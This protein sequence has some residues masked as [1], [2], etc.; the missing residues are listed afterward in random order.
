MSA[1][2]KK[3]SL[4]KKTEQAPAEQVSTPVVAEQTPAPVTEQTTTTATRKATIRPN[5]DTL[6]NVIGLMI[7]RFSLDEAEVRKALKGHVPRRCEYNG[8]SKAGRGDIKRAQNSYSYY[9]KSIQDQLK[10]EFKQFAERNK[11]MSRRWKAMSEAERAPF[12]AQAAADK[13]RYQ[14]EVAAMT[15]AATAP[16]PVETVA[17]PAV[18]GSVAKKPRRAAKKADA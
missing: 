11:E 7:S 9:Q 1:A 8:K 6:N 16:A 3:V 2:V 14:A 15:P 13:Q 18:E 4:K 17:A 12:E 10:G 5:M